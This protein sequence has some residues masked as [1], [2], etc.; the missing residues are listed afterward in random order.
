MVSWMEGHLLFS[1]L[2]YYVLVLQMEDLSAASSGAVIKATGSGTLVA[3][4][5]SP[6]R[7][8]G[9]TGLVAS[10]TRRIRSSAL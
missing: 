7:L 9:W 4:L 6:V 5:G 3:D 8:P 2:P 1:P 10:T